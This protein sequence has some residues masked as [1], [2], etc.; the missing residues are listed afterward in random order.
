MDPLDPQDQRVPNSSTGCATT[1]NTP[2]EAITFHHQVDL[3]KDSAADWPNGRGSSLV[4]MVVDAV[5][6]EPVSV[7]KFPANREMN[8]QF[9]RKELT[10][11]ISGRN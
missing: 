1:I 7:Q 3:A 11:R 6:C 9:Q 2:E 4:R 10:D 8:R 5:W